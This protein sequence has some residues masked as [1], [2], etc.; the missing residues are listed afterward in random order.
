MNWRKTGVLLSVVLFLHS[1][2]SHTET[3]NQQLSQPW[4]SAIFL[5]IF[6]QRNVKRST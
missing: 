1:L 4:L 3:E 5:M 6:F 2:K